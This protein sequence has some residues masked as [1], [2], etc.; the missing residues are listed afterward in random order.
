MENRKHEMKSSSGSVAIGYVRIE[1]SARREL[2]CTVGIHDFEVSSKV[3]VGNKVGKLMMCLE[4]WWY[5][6]NQ[7]DTQTLM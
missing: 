6:E 7:W 2:H 1:W 4:N 5:K 3:Y